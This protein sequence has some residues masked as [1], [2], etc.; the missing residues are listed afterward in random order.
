MKPTLLALVCTVLLLTLPGGALAQPLKVHVSRFTVT[1]TP[2]KDELAP[3]LQGIL[4]SRLNP[5]RVQLVDTADKAELL[6]AG[7]Y[8]LFGRLFS[9]D[10]QIRNSASGRIRTVFEQG[11]DQ[12]DL[13]PAMGRLAQ[14][15]DRELAKLTQGSAPAAAASLPAAITPDLPPPPVP[16]PA[17]GYLVKG[18]AAAGSPGSQ[19]GVE[20]PGVFSGIALGRI[21][22]GGERELFLTAE[23]KIRYYRLGKSGLREVAEVVIPRP[24]KVLGID[25][26]DLDGDGAP[27]LYVT[28]MD[29]E[30]LTSQVYL[31]K[32]GGLEM[33]AGNLPFFFRGIGPDFR[34]RTIYTQ[35]LGA[36][37]EFLSQ[38]AP[39]VK[40]GA[41]FET[42]DRQKLPGNG[43]IFNCTG[44]R[45]AAGRVLYAVLEG[46]GHIGVSSPEG[47]QLWQSSEKFGGSENFF[48]R[49]S[50][51][52]QRA[53]GGDRLWTFLEQ[54]IIATADG[55]LLVPR[56]QGTL[57]VGNSRSYTSHTL[58]AFA[59]SGSHLKEL[60]HS[61]PAATYLADFAFDPASGEVLLL[62]VVQKESMFNQGVTRISRH[63][64]Q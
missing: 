27:E 63:R 8:A 13:L 26:A 51:A 49:E 38:V 53:T 34:S 16:S 43:A 36:T 1:G 23:R 30:S 61:K 39:L 47:R 21:L 29:R 18:D 40:A 2:A 22:P 14:Q 46:D 11:Q 31:P 48:T 24:A 56:N 45:D 52:E 64:V 59:W 60:W 17:E 33:I 44:F 55:K 58:H 41:R 5:E 28:V 62:E 25:S 57:S 37:G 10:V 4:S 32:E 35:E 12:D 54:R 9:L 3:T 50:L 15:I 42:R 19:P 7:S 20:L 6:L